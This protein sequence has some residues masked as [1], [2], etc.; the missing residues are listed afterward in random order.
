MGQKAPFGWAMT[1]RGG[2]RRHLRL[3]FLRRGFAMTEHVYHSFS[4]SATVD[5]AV[6]ML[7]RSHVLWLLEDWA[8]RLQVCIRGTWRSNRLGQHKAYCALM[9]AGSAAVEQALR[10]GVTV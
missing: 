10:E 4:G 9:Q 6:A 5:E 2:S 1:K 8:P 7:S 3:S